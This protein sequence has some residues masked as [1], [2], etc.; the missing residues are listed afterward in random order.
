RARARRGPTA[1]PA[2]RSARRGSRRHRAG[3][4]PPCRRRSFRRESRDRAPP[5]RASTSSRQQARN[6]CASQAEGLDSAAGFR[7]SSRVTRGGGKTGVLL[8]NLGTPRSPRPG[9]VRA[10]LREFLM[11]PRVLDMPAVLR[12]P[13][14]NLVI[15]PFRAPRSAE[16]YR[17]IWGPEGSPQ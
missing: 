12:W 11:D 4:E 17:K 6:A 3:P 10:Y 8:L 9:D 5:W 2:R 14:V 7:F 1:H 16:L 15:A 13:L